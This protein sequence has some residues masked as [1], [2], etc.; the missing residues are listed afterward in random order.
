M[1]LFGKRIGAEEARQLGLVNEL[2]DDPFSRSLELARQLL[3]LPRSSLCRAK[4]LVRW[5]NSDMYEREMELF[6]SCF[7]GGPEPREGVNAFLEKR[8]PKF[9]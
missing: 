4:E 2:S 9:R 1:V 6:A 5:R 3:Q 7:E 8:K